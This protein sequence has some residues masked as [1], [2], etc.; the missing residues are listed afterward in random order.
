MLR[1]AG[2]RVHDPEG[3]FYHFPDF[4]PLA[5]NIEKFGVHNSAELC[6]AILSE[7]LVATVPGSAFHRPENEFTLRMSYCNF[8]GDKALAASELI[9]LDKPLPDDFVDTYCAKTLEST[10]RIC[11]FV[12]RKP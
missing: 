11:D 4:S 1:D 5:D 2:A 7:K 12:S 3:A 8:D 6:D 10:K 9:S